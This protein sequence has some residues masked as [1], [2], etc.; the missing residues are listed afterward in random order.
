MT[1]PQRNYWHNEA[2][3]RG[4]YNVPDAFRGNCPCG[5]W[6]VIASSGFTEDGPLECRCG[7]KY[8]TRYVVDAYELIYSLDGKEV[9]VNRE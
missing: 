8:Y 4:V 2:A 6:L 7:R 1:K 3:K 9:V 5:K